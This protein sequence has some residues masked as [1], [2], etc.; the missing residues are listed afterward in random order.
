MAKRF[1][2]TNKY[3]K[4]FIRSLE[5]PYKL[6]WDYLYHDCDHAGIWIVDFEIAQIYIGNDAPINYKDALEY[7]NTDKVRIIEFDSGKKWFIPS[8]I[9]FQYGEL[10][11]QNRAHNSVLLI[12][13]NND[14]LKYINKPLISPLKGAMDKDKDKDK[15][16]ENTRTRERK[17]RFIKPT[18][19]EIEDYCKERNNNIDAEQFYNFYESKNWMIGKNKMKNWRAAI[20]TWE[21]NN[22]EQKN[23]YPNK[24]NRIGYREQG[25]RYRKAD[26][27]E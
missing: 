11:E 26:Y 24:T 6:L 4:P 1:T 23:N 10:S 14:L 7:F 5:A 3:R 20:I 9:S 22:K 19:E 2:D 18:M 8:F 16:M 27:E 13:K 17:Y 15:D 25:K 12:L 21:R